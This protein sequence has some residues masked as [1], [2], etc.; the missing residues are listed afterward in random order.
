MPQ[1]FVSYR[2]NDRPGFAARLSDHLESR[3]GDENVFR[4]RE[5]IDSGEDFD[6]VLENALR[7]SKVVVVLIG[8][9]WLYEDGTGEKP[10]RLFDEGDWVRR[11]I[12]IAIQLDK[13]II[14]VLLDGVQI[15][16]AAQVPESM[17]R[18]CKKQIHKLD[19]ERWS[20]D[21]GRLVSRLESILGMPAAVAGSSQQETKSELPPRKKSKLPFLVGGAVA[22]V[23]VAGVLINRLED[24][25]QPAARRIDANVVRESTT[26]TQINAMEGQTDL[27]RIAGSPQNLSIEADESA[28]AQS[29]NPQTN[30]QYVSGVEASVAVERT[31]SSKPAMEAPRDLTG[32]WF[33]PEDEY[34][35]QIEQT[36][37]ELQ[38]VVFDIDMTIGGSGTGYWN[39]DT[40]YYE[41]YEDGE[42]LYTGKAQLSSDGGQ[43]IARAR[44]PYGDTA[45]YVLEKMTDQQLVERIAQIQAEAASFNV[46]PSN[47]NQGGFQPVDDAGMKLL[48]EQLRLL[49]ESNQNSIRNIR[50]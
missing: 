23:I 11:E 47:L 39:G 1:I 32:N 8:P 17:E 14:P 5:G 9:N 45:T 13:E 42:G 12:E 18:F 48:L 2:R 35:Y 26:V 31:T 16:R 20:Y 15:P 38:M 40:V 33:D 27:N 34:I 50:G 3:F 41:F 22:T 49:Q 37:K 6:R 10:S 30:V 19:D 46:Q 29:A 28:D 7:E 4:D 36:G 43:L 21:V 24:D 44:D 25:T